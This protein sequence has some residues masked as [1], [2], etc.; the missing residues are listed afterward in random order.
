[1][2]IQRLAD[3][4]WRW[5]NR[6]ALLLPV[7]GLLVVSTAVPLLLPQSPVPRGN[8]AAFVRWLA[9]L[10]AP[11]S[12]V[13][14]PLSVLGLLSWRSSVWVRLLYT[15]LALTL[16]AQAER[17]IRDWRAAGTSERVMRI[18]VCAGGVAILSGWGL[19]TA[20]GWIEPGVIAWPDTPC[21]IPERDIVLPPQ[22]PGLRLW[23]GTFGLYLLP[24]SAAV[25]LTVT[26]QDKTGTT[27]S[28]SP[29][30]QVEPMPELQFALSSQSPDSYF[31]VPEAG[32][33][34]RLSASWDE[35]SA[36]VQVQAYRLASGELLA[37]AVVS[38]VTSMLVENVRVLIDYAPLAHFEA[39]Y[40]PGAPLLALG[41]LA[42]A[43]G[44]IGLWVLQRRV[45]NAV[46]PEDETMPAA[47][48]S[49]D[50]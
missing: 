31:A 48:P 29:S 3:R 15:L 23:P 45:G 21:V 9:L 6:D 50:I 28:L 7:L 17:A 19:Q 24:E 41:T 13:R 30:A 34:F 49:P 18:L 27:L 25:G 44:A 43:A 38:E 33:V 8:D 16:A 26:A 10:P 40:N 37:E 11:F 22:Q 46:Q 39:V 20:V 5:L 42:Y 12:V 1:M 14:E 2:Q 4:V 35:N 32:L 47:E 36:P